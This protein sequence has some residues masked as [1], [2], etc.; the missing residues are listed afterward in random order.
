M[1]LGELSDVLNQ[2]RPHYYWDR[3]TVAC[4][5]PTSS[6]PCCPAYCCNVEST[7]HELQHPIDMS[8]RKTQTA[9]LN[10]TFQVLSWGTGDESAGDRHGAAAENGRGGIFVGVMYRTFDKPI[11]GG[12]CGVCACGCRY[13]HRYVG[14]LFFTLINPA[15]HTILEK[16]G[17]LRCSSPSPCS[18]STRS[19]RAS[20][21]RGKAVGPGICSR[22]HGTR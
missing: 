1:T 15:S 16:A 4:A 20:W 10:G 8:F 19:T 7:A 11:Q 9:S 6:V 5:A 13:D 3:S 12:A 21:V 2:S 17:R 14:W 22:S 18:T